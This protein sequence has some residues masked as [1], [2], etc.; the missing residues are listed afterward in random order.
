LPTDVT[1]LADPLL[2]VFE[3][4]LPQLP[5]FIDWFLGPVAQANRLDSFVVVK[6]KEISVSL[7]CYSC[8]A[9]QAFIL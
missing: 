9:L 7:W 4:Y 3:R 6:P 2:E 8:G 5:F 1:A